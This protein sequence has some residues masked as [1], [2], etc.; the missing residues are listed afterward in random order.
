LGWLEL[1]Y[2]LAVARVGEEFHLAPRLGQTRANASATI[3][4]TDLP[5]MSGLQLPL[6]HLNPFGPCSNRNQG[7]TCP[8]R[9]WAIAN[10]GNLEFEP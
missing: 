3:T 5:K 1:S 6:W 9:T 2:V 10:G 7:T 8:A 4:E